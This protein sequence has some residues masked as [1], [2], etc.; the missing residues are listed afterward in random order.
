MFKADSFLRSF[1]GPSEVT[2]PAGPSTWADV[3]VGSAL[4]RPRRLSHL[5]LLS[6]TSQHVLDG[7]IGQTQASYTSPHWPQEALG[8]ALPRDTQGI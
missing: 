5:Q 6:G 7:L 2:S 3:S 1:L 4:L 8:H